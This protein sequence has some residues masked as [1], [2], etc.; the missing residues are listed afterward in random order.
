MQRDL[1]L[2]DNILTTYKIKIAGLCRRKSIN[3][4]KKNGKN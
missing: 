4:K 3:T 2:R 1:K